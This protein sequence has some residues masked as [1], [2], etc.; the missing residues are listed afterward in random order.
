MLGWRFGSKK[1]YQQPAPAAIATAARQFDLD[2]EKL[3]RHQGPSSVFYAAV[4]QEFVYRND[5]PA[6]RYFY[7]D[8]NIQFAYDAYPVE[9]DGSPVFVLDRMTWPEASAWPFSN[10]DG[11]R[12]RANLAWLHAIGGWR[13][14]FNFET[15]KPRLPANY[16]PFSMTLPDVDQGVGGAYVAPR[17]V[18]VV[19]RPYQSTPVAEG[20]IFAYADGEVQFF[21]RVKF[22]N[23]GGR[24]VILEGPMRVFH[25]PVASDLLDARQ[26]ECAGENLIW[27]FQIY[28]PLDIGTFVRRRYDEKPVTVV[29]DFLAT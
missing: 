20:L 25:G 3:K 12:A 2:V 8:D 16:K 24:K 5:P 10:A 4:I 17:G 27:F 11:D 14:A 19:I 23:M 13:V 26:R 28:R 9:E 21:F 1:K 29:F 15:S 7:G 6:D 18:I 22:W